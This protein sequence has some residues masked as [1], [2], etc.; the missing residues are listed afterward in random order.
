MLLKYADQLLWGLG[1]HVFTE[2][3]Q[4]ISL[5]TDRKYLKQ[6]TK[7]TLFTRTLQTLLKNNK[8]KRK[9]LSVFKVS[10]TSAPTLSAKVQ[11]LGASN[12]V[13][14]RFLLYLPI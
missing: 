2:R 6:M 12:L 5:T 4:V 7:K 8:K 1:I 14:F 13:V 11:T 9:L 10:Y 3:H